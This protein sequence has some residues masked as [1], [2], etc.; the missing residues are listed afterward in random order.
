MENIIQFPTKSVRDWLVIEQSMNDG[1]SSLGMSEAVHQRLVKIMKAFWQETLSFQFNLSTTIIFPDPLSRDE[2]SSICSQL[3]KNIGV[4][5]RSNSKI[6]QKSY[7]S[8]GLIVRSIFVVSLACN[9]D[10]GLLIYTN[11]SIEQNKAGA[12][13]TANK[14]QQDAHIQ[15]RALLSPSLYSA[16]IM[17]QLQRNLW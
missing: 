17:T 4:L 7:F 14:Q 16:A 10:C 9:H 5:V 15:S 2:V 3:G 8:K 12:K 1:L 6:L 11:A 13:F